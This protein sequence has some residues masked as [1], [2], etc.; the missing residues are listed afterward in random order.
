MALENLGRRRSHS[1]VILAIADRLNLYLGIVVRIT[2]LLVSLLVR[3]QSE[4]CTLLRLCNT[5]RFTAERDVFAFPATVR[6]VRVRTA[7]HHSEQPAV[8]V[9][10]C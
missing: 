5:D 2:R 7:H 9:F 1:V 3:L 6:R 10:T 4:G 8:S